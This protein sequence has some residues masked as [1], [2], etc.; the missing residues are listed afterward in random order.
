MGSFRT[1][2]EH[3]K[4]L[5]KPLRVARRR[6][7][8]F[9]EARDMVA[10]LAA[11]KLV[12]SDESALVLRCE[13]KSGF[14]SPAAHVTITVEGPDGIPSS[15]LNVESTTQGGLLSRDKA[16]VAEFL[17]PFTRRVC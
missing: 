12:D 7:E 5:H 17:E 4:P 11:W 16:N 9:A 14:L 15:T 1:S 6:E 10:D 13:R 2:D 3:S 8:L